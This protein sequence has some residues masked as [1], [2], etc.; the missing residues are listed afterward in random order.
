MWC[1]AAEFGHRRW[2]SPTTALCVSGAFDAAKK[3]GIKVIYGM[4]A[5]MYD[6]TD[7]HYQETFADEYVVFDIETTGLN[8]RTCHIIEIGAVRMR[9]GEIIDTFSTF[10]SPGEPLTPQIIDLTGITDDML[11]DAP[12][13]AEVLRAFKEFA[14]DTPLAAHNASFDMSFILRHGE[15]YGIDFDNT[16]LDT[17]WLIKRTFP[18]QKSYSLGKLAAEFGI[19]LQHHRA[20]GDATATAQLM[21]GASRNRAARPHA[22]DDK[23]TPSTMLYCCAATTQGFNCTSW[24]RNRT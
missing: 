2:P 16:W 22:E 13:P 21:P 10:V 20:L 18:S 6:D 15:A 14:G 12:G 9:H 11:K 4:E 19:P 5:Y 3:L 7:D 17:L 24:Y 1:R 23:N 8:P